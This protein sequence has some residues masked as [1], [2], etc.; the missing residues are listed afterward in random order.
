M[1]KEK[2]RGRKPLEER[3]YFNRIA[4]LIAKGIF[5]LQAAKLAGISKDTYYKWLNNNPAF[6]ELIENAEANLEL[7][8]IEKINEIGANTKNT[9]P[10]VRLLEGRFKDRWSPKLTNEITGPNGASVV[11]KVDAS[12]GYIPPNNVLGIPSTLTTTTLPTL[13]A[14]DVDKAEPS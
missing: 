13:T 6:N 7:S 1:K 4:K 14:K 10:L 3:K 9:Q 5:P 2:K 11:F 8:W 12:G